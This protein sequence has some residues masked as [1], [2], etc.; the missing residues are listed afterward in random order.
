MTHS[1]DKGQLLAESAS[2]SKA[3]NRNLKAKERSCKYK[4]KRLTE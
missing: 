4:A 3:V 1:Y 2:M